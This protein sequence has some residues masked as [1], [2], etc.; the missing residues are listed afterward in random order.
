MGDHP[1][2]LERVRAA[3][4]ERRLAGATRFWDGAVEEKCS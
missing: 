4:F 2:R 1:A 3:S